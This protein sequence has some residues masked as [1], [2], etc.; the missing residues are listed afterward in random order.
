ML[1]ESLSV[2]AF[3]PFP[4]RFGCRTHTSEMEPLDGAL[5]SSRQMSSKIRSG[6]MALIPQL[7]YHYVQLLNEM[8]K[9]RISHSEIRGE[10]GINQQVGLRIAG[11]IW[12]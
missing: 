6:V 5:E 1:T 8:L 3:L 9:L 11:R 4:T 2:E 12:V 10:Q 7:D